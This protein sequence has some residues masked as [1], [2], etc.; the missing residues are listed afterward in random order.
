[1]SEFTADRAGLL[2]CQNKDAALNAIIKMAGVP[3]KYFNS[4]NRDVFLEQAKQFE[5]NLS[6]T[7]KTMRNV[8]ILDDSHPWTILRAAELIKWMESGEYEKI[9]S[10]MTPVKCPACG[11]YKAKVNKVCPI[12]GSDS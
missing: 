1:M 10:N 2:T 3:Q 12:C 4:L 5:M 7:E 11:H 8:S 6:D 9:L